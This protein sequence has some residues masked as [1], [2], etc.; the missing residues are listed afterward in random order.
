V[1]VAGGVTGVGA[2]QVV[3]KERGRRKREEKGGERREE[4]ISSEEDEKEKEGRRR[5][6]TQVRVLALRSVPAHRV[7]MTGWT[8]RRRGKLAES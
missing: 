7:A 8:G 3:C 1:G 2:L 4:S 5:T 6:I